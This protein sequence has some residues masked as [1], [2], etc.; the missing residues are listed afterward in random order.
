MVELLIVATSSSTLVMVGELCS[1]RRI[2]TIPW[3]ISSSWF[4]PAIPS[5]GCSP[6]VTLR[7]VLDQHRGSAVRRNHGVGETIDGTDQ[8]DAAHNRGLRADVDGV[9][10][11][12]DV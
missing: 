6:T 8:T 11:D 1:P 7:D 9:A 5:L 3:T 10:A 12:I 4:S 2:S